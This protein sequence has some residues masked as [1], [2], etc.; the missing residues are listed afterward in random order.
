M[1]GR[2][3]Y[4][5]LIGGG[6]N[7]KFSQN[8]VIIWDDA[9]QKVVI[10]LEFNAVVQSVRLSRSRIV[11]ILMS[12]VHIYAFSS[13]PQPQ[14]VFETADNPLGL[15]C[16]S[17]KTLA[18]PGRTTG[19]VNLLDLDSG[20]ISI[21]PAHT[22]NISALAMSMDGQLLATASETG[23]LVRV[24]ST[25]TGAQINELR[26]GMDK[27]TIYS[28]GISPNSTK[29]AVISD[30]STL[31]VF[32]LTSAANEVNQNGSTGGESNKRFSFLGKVPL[33]PKYFS[34]QWSFTHTRFEGQG[35]ST[36]GWVTDDSIVVA[37]PTDCRWEKFVLLDSSSV[38]GGKTIE[39]EGW[40]RFVEQSE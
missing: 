15:A 35:R 7:P 13:P 30:K 10:T 22:T 32:D 33:L 40:R 4:L 38:E 18:Y 37:S 31:H 1:L 14:H 27:A 25:A 34:S 21:I 6:R 5:A 36:L 28:L 19:H 26:R 20:N 23:T 9:K 12:A 17:N 24:Y 11:I 2:S 29:L 8:K 39:R 16:M 3:N